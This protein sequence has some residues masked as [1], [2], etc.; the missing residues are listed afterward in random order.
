MGERG[1]PLRF[2]RRAR[3]GLRPG[4]NEP[5]GIQF[6]QPSPNAAQYTELLKADY[7]AIKSADPNAVVVAAALGAVVDFGNLT[8]NPVRFVSEMY[9]AGAAGYFDALS[10]HPYL[11]NQVFSQQGAYPDAPLNQAK[12]IY[13]LMVANGDGNKKI[14]ATEYGQPS[15]LVSQAS[16]ALFMGDFLRTWRNLPFAGPTFIHQLVD[17]N[18][19]SPTE[20][21][22]GLFDTNWIPKLALFTVKLV[23]E[24]NKLIEAAANA[25][26]L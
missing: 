20:A 11:Y 1:S 5:N 10:F 6:W 4:R 9:A 12:R 24:E 13:A 7:T 2:R 18:D 23:L 8:V 17:T 15:S 26:A 19:A 22:F 21:S 14:W 25:K 16:Q 3:G